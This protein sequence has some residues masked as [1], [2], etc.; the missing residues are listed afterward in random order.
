MAIRGF[1]S[2]V[3]GFNDKK[4]DSLIKLDKPL[5][6]ELYPDIGIGFSRKEE[7]RGHES[8]S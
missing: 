6:K 3:K 8:K 7:G 2:K 5:F 1:N 4:I